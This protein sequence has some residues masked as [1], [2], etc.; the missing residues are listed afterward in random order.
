MKNYLNKIKPIKQEVIHFEGKCIVPVKVH[1]EVI[2]DENGLLIQEDL[3][4]V[5]IDDK[6]INGTIKQN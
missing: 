4:K 2:Y 1:T 3:H 6:V 5:F